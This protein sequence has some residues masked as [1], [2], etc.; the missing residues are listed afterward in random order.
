MNLLLVLYSFQYYWSLCKALGEIKPNS[1]FRLLF[2]EGTVWISNAEAK[3]T[4]ITLLLA[5]WAMYFDEQERKNG[6]DPQTSPAGR[7]H[8]LAEVKT[9]LGY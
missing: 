8:S 6:L 9:L 5:Y 7:D 4:F 1:N 3:F 2:Q